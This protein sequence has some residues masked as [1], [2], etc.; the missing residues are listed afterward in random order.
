VSQIHI[1]KLVAALTEL[2]EFRLPTIAK[3]LASSIE[4]LYK[5]SI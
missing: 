4:N 2:S 5:A 3:M 1:K